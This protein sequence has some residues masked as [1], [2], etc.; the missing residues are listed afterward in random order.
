[1]VDENILLKSSFR[2]R[3]LILIRYRK[4]WS[5]NAYFNIAFDVRFLSNVISTS[6]PNAGI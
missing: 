6:G 2:P 1:M 5:N 3:K 4:F